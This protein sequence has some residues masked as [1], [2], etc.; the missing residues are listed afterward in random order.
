MTNQRWG[1]IFRAWIES[2]IEVQFDLLP[3]LRDRLREG[4]VIVCMPDDIAPYLNMIGVLC[5]DSENQSFGFEYRGYYIHV[6][7]W[8]KSELPIG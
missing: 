2:A 7:Q 3:Y 5:Y 6:I 1:E 8:D 4:D